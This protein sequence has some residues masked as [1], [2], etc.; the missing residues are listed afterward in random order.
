MT[1]KIKQTFKSSLL[2]NMAIMISG[3]VGAQIIL[4]L[5]SPII[6]RLYGPEAYGVMGAFN[7][8][9]NIVIP[10]AALTYPDTIILPK[11]D[12]HAKK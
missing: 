10:I 2:K 8:I 4:L 6:T 5:L 3:S 9:I 1:E 11:K 7:S 12:H